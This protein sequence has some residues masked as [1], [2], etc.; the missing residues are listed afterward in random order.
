MRLMLIANANEKKSFDVFLNVNHLGEIFY[1]KK[2]TR[3][4]P[5]IAL[6]TAI[7]KAT[8]EEMEF[9]TVFFTSEV[10]AETRLREIFST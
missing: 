7:S 6:D 4:I 3:W 5:N 2:S 10:D 8:E 1:D 9:G